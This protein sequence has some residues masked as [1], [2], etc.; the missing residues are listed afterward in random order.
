MSSTQWTCTAR[1]FPTSG[2]ELLDQSIR[3]D[4]ETLPTY[5]PEKYYPV[6]QVWLAKNVIASTYVVLKVYVTGQGRDHE[7][8]MRIYK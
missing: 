8:E 1:V 6:N 2:F 7:R 4:E 3:L 5:Q